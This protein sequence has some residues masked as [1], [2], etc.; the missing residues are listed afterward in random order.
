M[1]TGCRDRSL[2]RFYPTLPPRPEVKGNLACRETLALYL[3][4]TSLIPPVRFAGEAPCRRPP[5]HIVP[6]LTPAPASIP[7]PQP[8]HWRLLPVSDSGMPGGLLCRRALHIRSAPSPRE[9]ALPDVGQHKSPTTTG[10]IRSLKATSH[11][12]NSS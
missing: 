1:D 5:I 8:G 4:G 2:Q 9:E 12:R 3:S 6:G 11:P 7:A 10:A